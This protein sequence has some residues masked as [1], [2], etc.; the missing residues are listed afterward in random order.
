[1]CEFT[2]RLV[3]ERFELSGLEVGGDLLDPELVVELEKPI[4]QSRHVL[5]GQVPDAGF[6]FLDFTHR[7]GPSKDTAND[8][9]FPRAG[10]KRRRRP[11]SLLSELCRHR[12]IFFEFPRNDELTPISPSRLDANGLYAR[13]TTTL[14]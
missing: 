12:I 4:P 6:K 1:L 8:S 3:D 9:T 7:I 13:D 5:A 2:A 14:G 10:W 11:S